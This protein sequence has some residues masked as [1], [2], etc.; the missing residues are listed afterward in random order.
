MVRKSENHICSLSLIQQSVNNLSVFNIKSLIS[1]WRL[2]FTS[3]AQFPVYMQYRCPRHTISL[4][5][6]SK[7]GWKKRNKHL[8]ENWLE[9][10]P[11]QSLFFLGLSLKLKGS[12]AVV[13]ISSF[14][15]KRSRFTFVQRLLLFPTCSTLN[16]GFTHKH[17]LTISLFPWTRGN[18]S[19]LFYLSLYHRFGFCLTLQLHNLF[20]TIIY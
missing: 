17:M 12:A 11:V 18:H 6:A 1:D 7:Y 19:K 2:P 8:F 3:D 15:S 20:H 14:D 13:W 16:K 9:S 10:V 5:N 4:D